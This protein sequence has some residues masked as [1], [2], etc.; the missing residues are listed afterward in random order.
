MSNQAES[1]NRR[2][3]AA[4]PPPTRLGS[5]YYNGDTANF[6]KPLPEVPKSARKKS[7]YLKQENIRKMDEIIPNND[8]LIKYDLSK[9]EQLG[10]VLDDHVKI[11]GGNQMHNSQVILD[12]LSFY[13]INQVEDSICSSTFTTQDQIS[14][15]T[16][17]SNAVDDELNRNVDDMSLT[18]RD[19]TISAVCDDAYTSVIS[20]DYEIK[21]NATK[22]DTNNDIYPIQIPGL[23]K[24]QQVLSARI[25]NAQ[26]WTELIDYKTMLK[27]LDRIVNSIDPSK[28]Y[29]QL[30]WIGQ[31]AS[32][33]VFTA[34]NSKSGKIVA[35][36]KMILSKQAKRH[37][38]INEIKILKKLNHPNIVNYVDSYRILDELWIAMEFLSGGTLTDIVTKKYINEYLI[39]AITKEILTG[40]DF[41]HRSKIIHRDIKSDNILLSDNG[42]VKL[43]DFGFCA[44]LSTKHLFRSTLIGTPYWMA[45][46]FITMS[47]Y[48]SKIDIWSLGILMI[49]MVDSVPPYINENPIRALYLIASNGKPKPKCVDTSLS[50][51]EFIGKSLEINQF[52]RPSAIQLLDHPFLDKAVHISNLIPLILEVKRMKKDSTK[53]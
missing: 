13:G 31:G 24:M 43:T 1:K 15:S 19:S 53:D 50:L 40:I 20:N 51:K 16:T 26:K 45:P 52:N 28:L 47:H 8:K 41:L 18:F 7:K 46:E 27:K 49:E 36:K 30:K 33:L 12:V 48:S 10:H 17:T 37:L 9:Q 23:E 44:S 32:G 6:T 39:A 42:N 38:I 35:I 3:S 2:N 11:N 34:K 5:F 25:D 4:P 22:E 14:I 29:K 21:H